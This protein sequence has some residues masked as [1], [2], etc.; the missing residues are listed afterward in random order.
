MNIH[1]LHHGVSFILHYLSL[2]SVS[3]HTYIRL[4]KVRQGIHRLQNSLQHTALYACT[5]VYIRMYI[6]MYIHTKVH[7]YIYSTLLVHSLVL[8]LIGT[9]STGCAA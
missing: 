7:L 8:V 3:F 9:C 6:H 2:P 1:P 5:H 4:N